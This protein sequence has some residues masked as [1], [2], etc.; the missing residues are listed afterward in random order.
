MARK[1]GKHKQK[2]QRTGAGAFFGGT[3]V[4]FFLCL[5]VLFGLGAFIYFK[6]SPKWINKTFKTNIDLGTEELNKLTIKDAVSHA[7]NLTQNMDSYTLSKLEKDFGLDFG[8]S[9]KG[10]DISTLKNVPL[11]KLGEELQNTLSQI[12]AAELGEELIDL[13][14]M[15]NIFGKEITYYFKSEDKRLYKKYENSE[16][17]DPVNKTEDFNYSY[18]QATGKIQIK[19]KSFN[20]IGREVKIKL[21]NLPLVSAITTYTSN[22]GDNL[23]LRELHDD[24][25]VELPS[26]IYDGNEDASVNEITTIIDNMYLAEFLGYTVDDSDPEN[27]I[28]KDDGNQNVTGIIYE[29]AIEK[30]SNISNIEDKI[31]GIT[32]SDLESMFEFDGTIEK[33]LEKTQTYYVFGS[34]VYEDAGCTVLVDFDYE[35]SNGFVSLD[36]MDFPIVDNKV[37]IVLKNLPLTTA[38]SA[39]ADNLGENITLRDLVEDYGIELPDYIYNGN[40]DKKINE[41]DGLIDELYLAEFLGYTVDDSDLDNIIVKDDGNQVVTGVMRDLAIKH[42]SDLENVE[43]LFS[44]ATS[45]DLKDLFDLSDMDKIFNKKHTYYVQGNQLFENEG[46]STLADFEYTIS[47]SVLKIGEQIFTITDGKAKVDLKYVPLTSAISTFTN[48]LGN[49]LTLGELEADYGVSLPNYIITDNEDKSINEIKSI[50]DDLYVGRI[51]G[52]VVSV[53]NGE[54]VSVKNGTKDVT[55]IMEIISKKKVSEL[56]NIQSDIEAETI[57]TL[58]DY[59]IDGSVVKDREGNIVTGVLAKVAKY[60]ILNVGNV[61]NDLVLGDV[62]NFAELNSGVFNLLDE[63]GKENI[64]VTEVADKLTEAIQ[65]STLLELCDDE[66]NLI[67]LNEVDKAKLLSEVDH[68]YNPETEKVVLGE[69]GL[70]ELLSYLLSLVPQI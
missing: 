69:M 70:N 35:I 48:N 23:T 56:S 32:A 22:L 1:I 19:N 18:N 14:D 41:I 31:E 62:F 17:K 39:F 67:S 38:I 43:D 64:K 52:Y 15:D 37:E 9:L 54:V 28:V 6:V 10:I 3:F 36:E 20:I 44:D 58:L 55:G 2:R 68:D 33:I 61:T 16:Y 49:N 26:Y 60:S 59:T 7:L 66:V 53:N 12:S 25:G 42:I 30:V 51:L 11:N 34:N 13:S 24:Y 40:Q 5:A 47:G 27:I 46:K 50:I 21:E 45:N 63:T 4:G 29:F 65:N 57:A 8:T